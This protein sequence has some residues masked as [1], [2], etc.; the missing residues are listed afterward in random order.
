[1]IDQ[2]TTATATAAISNRH[3]HLSIQTKTNKGLATVMSS[4]TQFILTTESFR[5]HQLRISRSAI[6]IVI[7]KNTNYFG[8]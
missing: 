3:T 1:M 7:K 6:V 5:A 8:W 2:V 4:S